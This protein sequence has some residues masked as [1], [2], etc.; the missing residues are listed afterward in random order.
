MVVRKEE[1]YLAILAGPA[2]EPPPMETDTVINPPET[3]HTEDNR[4]IKEFMVI[5]PRIRPNMGKMKLFHDYVRDI[6]NGRYNPSIDFYEFGSRWLSLFNYNDEFVPNDREP[7][8]YRSPV[9]DWV[10][11]AGNPY[12]PVN[13]IKDGVKI[14]EIPPLYDSDL[15]NIDNSRDYWANAQISEAM[16][17]INH[18]PT[19]MESVVVSEIMSKYHDPKQFLTK[20]YYAMNEIFRLYGV[21]RKRPEW[22]IELEKLEKGEEVATSTGSEVDTEADIDYDEKDGLTADSGLIEDEF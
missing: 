6:D 11:V 4:S 10:Q 8:K 20:H 21:E 2:E 15:L 5:D 22:L 13:L 19:V 3:F 9:M 7:L 12:T 16:R 18:D 1:D 14:A 17:V